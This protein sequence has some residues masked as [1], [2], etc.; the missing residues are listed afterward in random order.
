MAFDP[1]QARHRA[2]EVCGAVHAARIQLD[3]AVFVGQAA[4][5]D[6]VVCG[7]FFDDVH[8]GDYGVERVGALADHLHCFLD[9]AQTVGTADGDR[10]ARGG[11]LRRL[12]LSEG[13]RRRAEGGGSER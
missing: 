13:G 11:G 2:G 7:V 6:G 4:V 10:F 1:A 12:G 9:G 3:H 8:A 5:T